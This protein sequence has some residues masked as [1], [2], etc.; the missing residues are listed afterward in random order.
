MANDKTEAPTPKRK[1]DARKKGETARSQELPQAVA[2]GVAVVMVPIV[3]PRLGHTLINEWQLTLATRVD[4]PRT[5]AMLLGRFTGS[6][7]LALWPLLAALAL[8]GLVSQFAMVG[9]PNPVHLKPKFHRISPKAGFK[10]I[11]SKQSLWELGRTTAKLG[12]LFLVGW[13]AYKG[14]VENLLVGPAPFEETLGIL[15]RDLAGFLRRI[16]VLAMV[17]GVI[18]AVVAKRRHTKSL[19]MTKQEVKDEHKQSEGN[20]QMKGAIRQRQMRLSRT[21]MIAAVA[22]ADVII[23]NP[24]H[25]AI[26][27][28]YEPGTLAPVVVAKGAGTVARKIREEGA[29]HGVP[30]IEDKP[31]ARALF[32]A[33]ELG[34]AI[35]AELYRA[36]ASVLAIVYKAKRK[37]AA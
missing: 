12:L 22:K 24:T 5:A 27:I 26:A 36:V 20:P 7:L 17:I 6:A 1:R 35:P 10:R 19:K 28:A 34:D 4:E 31:V 15:G 23:T 32:K 33:C 18:D 25:L 13:G 3:L 11:F 30:I 16:A 29:K 21:R 9:M 37:R 8:V 14:A 2:F